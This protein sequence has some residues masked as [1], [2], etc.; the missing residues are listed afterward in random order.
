[1][2]HCVDAFFCCHDLLPVT[3]KSITW[4][5]LSCTRFLN[6]RGARLSTRVS[7]PTTKTHHFVCPA[8]SLLVRRLLA[9]AIIFNL[10]YRVLFFSEILRISCMYYSIPFPFLRIIKGIIYDS[11]HCFVVVDNIIIAN[12]SRKSHCD[13]THHSN[14]DDFECR[15]T[16]HNGVG[17]TMEPPY[18]IT[19]I[20]CPS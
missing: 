12:F 15:A 13:V 9:V 2:H 11:N 20:V 4:C 8:S 19:C 6:F 17:I 18:S 10:R 7:Y 1:M 16:H 3:S 14:Y 5:F